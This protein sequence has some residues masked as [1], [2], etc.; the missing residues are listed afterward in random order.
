SQ[1]DIRVAGF[2]RAVD[3]AAHDGDVDGR[4]H[5]GETLLDLVGDADDIDLDTA[6][7]WAGDESNA[8]IAQFERAQDFVGDGNLFFRL[9]AQ[10]D[11]DGVTDASGEQ[12]T[13]AYRRLHRA[14]DQRPGLGDAQV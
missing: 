13:Q 10:A 1:S 14:G 9:R 4:L 11:A 6:T 12:Q 5:F 3:D 8:T 7:G 2:A